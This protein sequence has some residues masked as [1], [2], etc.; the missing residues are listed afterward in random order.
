MNKNATTMAL[1]KV[2]EVPS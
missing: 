1:H 2:S